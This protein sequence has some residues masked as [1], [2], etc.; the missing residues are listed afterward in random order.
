MLKIAY[1]K[2]FRY[3]LEENHRFPME[4]YDLIPEQLI[5]ENTCTLNNFFNP[6]ELKDSDVLRTHDKDYFERL[7]S[8]SLTK[9][10]LRSIGF[11]TCNT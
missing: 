11:P 1:N 8:L 7:T 10:E 4:K 6:K 2:I 3:K 5:N 9:K